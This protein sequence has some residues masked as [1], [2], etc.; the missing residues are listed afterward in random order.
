MLYTVGMSNINVRDVDSRI[1]RE[2][3]STAL[4]EGL[5]VGQLLNK[6]LGE[7]LAEQKAMDAEEV[8]S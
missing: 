2:F 1:W 7:W 4:T 5:T 8:A 6:V 3:R